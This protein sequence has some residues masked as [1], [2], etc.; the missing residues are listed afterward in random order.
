[1]LPST[2]SYPQHNDPLE[3][4]FNVLSE[5]WSAITAAYDVHAEFPELK[6][7]FKNAHH[8]DP[9]ISAEMIVRNLI[10]EV[11]QLVHRFS[12]WYTQPARA[13]GLVS[14]R[15]PITHRNKWR[16]AP[17]AIQKWEGVIDRIAAE[18][19]QKNGLVDAILFIDQLDILDED[20]SEESVVAVCECKPPKELLIKRIFLDQG[21]II[22]R[23]CEVRFSPLVVD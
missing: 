19:Y 13:F 21:A 12:R 17:E 23:E 4:L 3:D 6:T 15:D 10:S 7:V 18:L 20:F 2:N 1:M 22:C 11:T 8:P 9:C 5:A 16:L 14:Y